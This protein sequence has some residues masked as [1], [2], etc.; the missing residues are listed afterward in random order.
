[1]TE[2]I[3]TRDQIRSVD[4]RAMN[5]YQ[6]PGVILMENAGRGTSAL[7]RENYDKPGEK[8]LAVFAGAGNNGGDGYVIA[9]HLHNA[10]WQVRVVL[11]V[12]ETKL[13]GDALVNYKIIK[14]MNV[15]VETIDK[16]DEILSWA[17]VAV[18]ALFGTGF[19]G[20]VRPP[21]DDLITKINDAGKPVVAVDVPSGLDCQT[22]QASETTIKAAF[23][24]TFVAVKAGMVEES[25]QQYVGKAI[26]VDIGVP[27]ELVEEIAKSDAG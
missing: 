27:R 26:P 8:H 13:K 11:A 12:D 3:L 10:G 21:V 4:S 17:D 6:M 16:A 24:A 5:E 20:E 14:N 9:R 15:P 25:A 1:M 22:G 19:S 2:L 23:T 18:D 7:I